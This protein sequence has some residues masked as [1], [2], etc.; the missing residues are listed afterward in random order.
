VDEDPADPWSAITIGVI[1]TE[2]NV[3]E[4]AVGRTTPALIQRGHWLTVPDLTTVLFV[5]HTL[6]YG[7]RL[8]EVFALLESDLRVQ[9]VFTVPPH[10]FGQ[11]VHGYLRRLGVTVIPWE[12]AVG[13]AFDLAVAAG[14]QDIDRLRA[15]VIR[16]SHGAG[17]IKLLRGDAQASADSLARFQQEALAASKGGRTAGVG[18]RPCACSNALISTGFGSAN[19]AWVT[20][21]SASA[22][23]R[24]S[25]TLPARPHS[26]ISTNRDVHT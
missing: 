1:I 14:S 11:G 17:H 16:M 4:S 22:C 24:P 8:R 15:P 7:K 25:S 3:M 21:S 26:I 23:V 2:G 6:T 5:I 10:A 12:Q 13:T 9:A 19:S 20:G 18:M